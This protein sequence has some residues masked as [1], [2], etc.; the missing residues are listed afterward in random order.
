MGSEKAVL[1]GMHPSGGGLGGVVDK[2]SWEVPLGRLPAT[3]LGFLGFHSSIILIFPFSNLFP[4]KQKC[5]LPLPFSL[6]CAWPLRTGLHLLLL[7]A[8]IN[9]NQRRWEAD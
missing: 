3:L 8:P 5:V 2:P 7:K 4:I 6:S 9:S 1:E